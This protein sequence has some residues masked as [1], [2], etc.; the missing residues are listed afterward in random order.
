MNFAAAQQAASIKA[1]AEKAAGRIRADANAEAAD[2]LEAADQRILEANTIHDDAVAFK[3]H[4]QADADV[5]LADADDKFAEASQQFARFL[6]QFKEKVSNLTLETAMD[7]DV[8]DLSN[9]Q[10]K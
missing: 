4:A 5:I 7:T 6:S 8:L 9:C 3:E 1:A 10:D 2:L